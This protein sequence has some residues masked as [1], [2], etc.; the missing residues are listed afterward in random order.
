MEKLLY[1]DTD[2]DFIRRYEL[3]TYKI[4]Y[5]LNFPNYFCKNISKIVLNVLFLLL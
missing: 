1:I 4:Y 3:P 5:F 2:L